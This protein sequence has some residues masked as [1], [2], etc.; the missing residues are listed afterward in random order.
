MVGTRVSQLL[1]RLAGA[2]S[3]AAATAATT[4]AATA[5]AASLAYFMS[6]TR[7]L[8]SIKS[9]FLLSTWGRLTLRVACCRCASLERNSVCCCCCS[10]PS[11]KSCCSSAVGVT[12]AT[13]TIEHKHEFD[14]FKEKAYLTFASCCCCCCPSYA[15]RSSVGVATHIRW[16]S[17]CCCRRC[18]CTF[19][20][21]PMQ[22]L[23]PK[24][25][26]P[27]SQQHFCP[28]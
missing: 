12:A 11:R 25:L 14:I 8:L 20:L 17:S 22:T 7:A 5:A 15:S 3:S 9:F 16:C 26:N 13:L 4:A 6:L 24:I 10:S 18:C 27:N 2:T 21:L 23:E 19:L 28:I 1:Q